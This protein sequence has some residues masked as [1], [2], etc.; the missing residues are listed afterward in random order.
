MFIGILEKYYECTN[1]TKLYI[2]GIISIKLEA[3]GLNRE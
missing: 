2:N 3:K 1:D